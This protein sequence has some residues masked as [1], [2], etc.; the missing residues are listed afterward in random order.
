MAAAETEADGPAIRALGALFTV[1]HVY[2]CDD[3]KVN[4]L[5]LSGSILDLEENQEEEQEEEEKES[6]MCITSDANVNSKQPTDDCSSKEDLE[7]ADHMAALG[8]PVSFGTTK[9]R[10]VATSRKKKGKLVKSKF[11]H[12]DQAPCVSKLEKEN[13]SYANLFHDSTHSISEG[14]YVASNH[15]ALGENASG[16]SQLDAGFTCDTS[17]TISKFTKIETTD[18]LVMEHVGYEIQTSADRAVENL[19]Q[20]ENIDGR[21]SSQDT[22]QELRSE[23]YLESPNKQDSDNPIVGWEFGNWRVIWDDYYKRNYFYNYK[24]QETTWYA[25]PGLE[26][27]AWPCSI[28][29]SNSFSANAVEQYSDIHSICGADR[30]Q[31]ENITQSQSETLQENKNAINQKSSKSFPKFNYV[32]SLSAKVRSDSPDLITNAEEV[33]NNLFLH[34]SALINDDTTDELD[35]VVLLDKQE[36]NAANHEALNVPD[37]LLGVAV[38]NCSISSSNDSHGGVEGSMMYELENNDET[39]VRN[40]WRRRRR[41]S[42]LTWEG[43]FEGLSANIF[44]YWCQRYSLFSQ[45]DSGIKMDEEG[46]YSVTPEAIARHHATRSCG[47]VVIDCF[48]GVGGNTIQFAIKNH[49]VIAIDIDPQKLELAYHN[50]T[51]YGVNHKIDFIQGDFFKMAARLKGDTVFLSPPWGGPDY[52]KVQTYDIRSML[53]PYDGIFLFKTASMIASKVVIFLPRN[54]DFNQLAELSLSVYPP[55]A[56]EVEKNILNG[57]FKAVTAYFTSTT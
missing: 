40:K 18:K 23:F 25:P 34:H 42:Q 4:D 17:L 50:S 7:L 1:S 22:L 21:S 54:V 30:D 15:D 13:H 26:Y 48:A 6:M 9:Q 12:E 44:K 43:E 29:T 2:L 51:I 41:Q 11:A 3:A 46:W 39:I 10:K 31:D 24:T 33:S 52:Q 55:W 8:L 38:N 57:K 35:S 53:K 32:D 19:D 27:L 14:E 49:H 36:Q 28:S 20:N 47:G 5:E 56:V 45:Y 16:S 37:A